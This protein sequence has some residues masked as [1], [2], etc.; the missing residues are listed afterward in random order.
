MVFPKVNC[1]G[2][3]AE[4][5][6]QVQGCG[7]IVMSA[8]MNNDAGNHRVSGG[9]DGASLTVDREFDSG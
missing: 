6:L 8:G 7:G 2:N 1:P 4:G 5:G 3:H 9:H